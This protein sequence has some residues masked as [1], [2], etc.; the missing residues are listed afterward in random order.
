LN[1]LRL[2]SIPNIVEILLLNL[3]VVNKYAVFGVRE[4]WSNNVQ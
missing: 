1:L 4:A 3:S 2:L